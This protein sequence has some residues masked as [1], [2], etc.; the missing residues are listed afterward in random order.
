MHDLWIMFVV[1]REGRKEQTIT[2]VPI[3]I[4]FLDMLNNYL[5]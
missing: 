2:R 4:K 1:M 5:T 3:I